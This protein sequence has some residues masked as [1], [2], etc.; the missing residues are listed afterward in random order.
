MLTGA[1]T[2]HFKNN[3]KWNGENKNKHKTPH[4]L[5]QLLEIMVESYWQGIYEESKKNSCHCIEHKWV[6]NLFS[7]SA[8]LMKFRDF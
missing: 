5:F 2:L 7:P 3:T 1:V 8:A 4:K 6:K